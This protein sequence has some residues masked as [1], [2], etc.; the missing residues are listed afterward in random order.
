[1]LKRERIRRRAYPTRDD[2]KRDVFD[3]IEKF[4]NPKRKHTNKGMLRNS[5]T[6]PSGGWLAFVW[7]HPPTT[8]RQLDPRF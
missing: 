7:Q 6:V 1:M 8:P 3:Y 2:A 4:Y 5:V